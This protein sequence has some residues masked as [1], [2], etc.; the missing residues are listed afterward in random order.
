M[1]RKHQYTLN[2]ERILLFQS[3][4]PKQYWFYAIL[5]TTYIIKIIPSPI[6]QNKSPKINRFGDHPDLNDLKIFG[7]LCYFYTI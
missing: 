4:L 3:K 2:V 5:E 1:E 7:S 6:L